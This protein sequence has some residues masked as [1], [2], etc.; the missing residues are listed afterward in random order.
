MKK[1]LCILLFFGAISLV[2]TAQYTDSLRS[3]YN[4]HS[5]YRYGSYFMKG[6]ERLTFQQLSQEFS[7]SDLG[8]ASYTK[9]RKYR[10]TSMVLRIISA[11]SGIAAIAVISNN[12]SNQN[13]AYGFLGGQLVFGIGAGRYSMLSAQSTDRALWQRNKDLL[14]PK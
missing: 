7:M 6:S 12:N 9:A 10:T 4:N 5:I 8:L 1:H 3:V 14:F 13:L 2:S 11:V